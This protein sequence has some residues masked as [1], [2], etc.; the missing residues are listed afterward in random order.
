M[1]KY[2]K[3]F[4]VLEYG[5]A[6]AVRH[7][8]GA[9]QSVIDGVAAV[10]FV[11]LKDA[12]AIG[13]GLRDAMPLIASAAVRGGETAGADLCYV[14]RGFLSG[15]LRA[16]GFTGARARELIGVSASGFLLDAIGEGADAVEVSRC[17]VE[18]AIVWASEVGENESAAA[19]AAARAAVAAA[20][21]VSSG[22][23]RAVHDALKDGVAGIDVVFADAARA[24]L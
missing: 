13:H 12:G 17:L 1:S 4:S 21:A 3:P 7:S 9:A 14:A 6:E 20:R 22:A 18:G 24:K 10:M 19:S 23:A 15:L 5:I 11:A 8:G 16:S 2:S